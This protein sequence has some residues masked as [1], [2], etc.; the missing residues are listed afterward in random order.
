MRRIWPFLP[1]LAVPIILLLQS[2][3]KSASSLEG[4]W[5]MEQGTYTSLR[6]SLKIETDG[7]D[8]FSI[9]IMGPK[10]FAVVEMFKNNPDSLFFA[11]V[12]TYRLTP[13]KYIE[14]YEASNV[15]YQV[16][17]SREFDY[18]LDGDRFTI[19]A[20]LQDAEL[21]EVWARVPQ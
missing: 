5:Q 15:G 6:D 10:H 16:G 14:T 8:R 21:H 17:T 9:K 19:T 1:L 13:T 12:G 2:C 11:A 7:T 4:T 20:S 3:T 18:S